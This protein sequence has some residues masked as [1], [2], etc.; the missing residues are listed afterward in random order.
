[1]NIVII[2]TG[3]VAHVF[4]MLLANAGHSIVQVFGHTPEHAQELAGLLHTSACSEWHRMDPE[5]DLYL[6]AVAD[7]ALYEIGKQLHL[8]GR[9]VAHTAGSV[10]MTVL[11]GISENTGIFYP[12]QSL[13]KSMPVITEIP[14]LI[15]ASNDFTKEALW[16]VARDISSDIS[17]TTDQERLQYHVAAVF[18]NN[19]TNHLYEVAERFCGQQT[20]DFRL[21]LPLAQETSRRLSLISPFEAMTGPAI[22]KDITTIS[23]HLGLLESDPMARRLYATLTASIQQFHNLGEAE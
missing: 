7:K 13:K 18:I 23:E 3:N 14:I 1:M 17:E 21:L 16:A 19:F 5:A 15:N 2:G 20:L 11:Q 12:L 10:P 4:G 6:I 9:I 22:R 8:P